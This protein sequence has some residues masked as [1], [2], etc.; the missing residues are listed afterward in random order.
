MI[1]EK[2][3]KVKLLKKKGGFL[4]IIPKNIKQLV[5]GYEHVIFNLKVR[6]LLIFDGNLI[7]K[8]NTNK[9]TKCRMIGFHRMTKV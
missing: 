1:I 9:S 7:N 5:K 8:S 2:K 4:S 3:L 6:D